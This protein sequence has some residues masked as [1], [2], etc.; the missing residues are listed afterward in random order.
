MSRAAFDMICTFCN[1]LQGKLL[2]SSKSNKLL[3]NYMQGVKQDYVDA[4]EDVPHRFSLL[5][6]PL[7]AMP[8]MPPVCH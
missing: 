4:Q 2:T 7:T 6:W 3:T 5:P 8:C 1:K